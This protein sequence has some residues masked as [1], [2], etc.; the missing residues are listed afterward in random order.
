MRRILTMSLL[1]MC[2]MAWMFSLSHDAMA[3]DKNGDVNPMRLAKSTPLD[4]PFWT[5]NRIGDYIGNNGQFVSFLPTGSAGLEWPLGSGNTAHFAGGIWLAGIKSGEIVTAAAEFTVEFQPG[6]VIN[7]EADNPQLDKYKTY[8]V[9]LEDVADPLSNPD[10]LNWPVEDGAPWIDV[11]G[12]GAYEP[13]DGDMPEIIGTSTL[14]S[15]FNDFNPTL[16]NN[17]FQ[18]KPMGVEVQL[19]AWAFDRPDAFGDM[20]FLK[21]TFINKSGVDI[22]SVFASLWNDVDVGDANDLVGSD[23]TLSLGYMYQTITDQLYGD[24]PPALGMDFFQGPIVP[25]PGDTANVSGRRVPGFKNLPMVSF[26]KYINGG[27]PQYSDPENGPEAYNFM[28]GFDAL[29]DPIP[30]PTTGQNTKFWH[31]GDPVTGTGWLDPEHG[32]KRF[33]MNSGPFTLAAGDTQEVVAGIIIA[34]GNTGVQ[35]VDL[36]RQ[37]DRIAQLAYDINFALPPSPP[38]PR[39]ETS[40]TAESILL[41]WGDRAEPY[42]AP[43]PIDLDEEGNPTE[44]TFQGYNVYQINAPV[45]GEGVSARKIA[46]F[47]IIDGITEIRDDVFVREIGQTANIVVQEGSDSGLQR[48]LRVTTDVFAGGQ[49]LIPNR[50]YYFAV[51]AYG[52]NPFGIPRTLESPIQIMTIRA[53]RPPLGTDLSTTSAVGDTVQA[54][55]VAGGSDGSIVPMVVDPS[56]LT[57]HEYEVGFREV[58]DPEH[59]TIV[60]DVIDVT[61][62]EVKAEGFTNQSDAEGPGNY[63]LVDGVLVKVLGAPPQ[64]K[65]NAPGREA[66][67]M[68]EVAYAGTPLTPDQ[69][70]GSGAPH[71]G[72]KVWHSLNSAQDQRYY[73]SAGGGGGDIGRLERNIAN[74]VPFD[75]EYRFAEENEGSYGWYPFEAGGQ[76]TQLNPFQLWRIGVSTPDDPSDDVRLIP[77]HFSGGTPVETF[78]HPYTDPAFGFPCTHWT[79]FYFDSRGYDAYESDASDGTLDDTSFGEVEYIARMIV[80]DFDGDDQLPPPGTVIRILTSKPNS[81]E[82]VFSFSTQAPVRGSTD[83]AKEQAAELVNVY[84]NPYKGFNIEER[85]PVNRFVTFTNLPESGARIQIF[86]LNGELISTME[87]G[88]S[89]FQQWDLRN[90]D[91]VPV[92]SGIYIARIDMGDLGVKVLKLAVLMPQERLD[93]F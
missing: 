25:S 68:V 81:P 17:L 64:I 77:V 33:L 35:S 23:T 86:T 15:V 9:N 70:D 7:G 32:D 62:G 50:K 71:G 82:D 28:N 76:T 22:D 37:A 46:T 20:L 10:Y 56:A 84:P 13:L 58:G 80:C 65:V 91:S 78:A 11:D 6:K 47:D 14:W 45:L 90:Q 36:L 16:H 89:Q 34:Q 26:A 3:R 79:Y 54:A 4:I 73:V 12:D 43:D 40:T 18:T 63:P 27:P 1:V 41:K 88:G 29:G 5:P 67:G 8:I 92:A 52:F 21:Y 66:D 49:P 48:H 93:V 55:R 87:T 74:A 42:V 24:N 61:T 83:V 53:A 72:N 51:T 59:P 69:F 31:A 38:N 39:V 19:L 85:D 57:G 30:D 60:Y 2:A 44:Y 75:F